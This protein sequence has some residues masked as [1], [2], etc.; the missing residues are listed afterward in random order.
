[1]TVNTLANKPLNILTFDASSDHCSVS[2]GVN[3][4]KQYYEL[5]SD[6]PRSHAQ[7]ILPM[8]DQVLEE[9][10]I[11]VS[12]VDLLSLTT[13]PGSFTGIRISVSVAQGLSYATGIPCLAVSSMQ[14]MSYDFMCDH[15]KGLNISSGDY[16]LCALDAR[17]QEVYWAL[18]K[19]EDTAS[20]IGFTLV[21]CVAPSITPNDEFSS[22]C[23]KALTLAIDGNAMSSS[24]MPTNTPQKVFGI[25]NAWSLFDED[26]AQAHNTRK[27][28]SWHFNS[29][30]QPTASG[31]QQYLKAKAF[32]VS[33]KLDHAFLSSIANELKKAENLEPLYL[34][35]EVSWQKRKRIRSESDALF[36]T[37]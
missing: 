31:I 14:A 36:D 9:A 28:F 1:M 11:R 27:D 5:L 2:L 25:G 15:R 18:Y 17:M 33:G 24:I 30:Q 19:Y 10:G 23:S 29:S 21:E 34:R 13:G 4:G 37:L 7:N 16:V 26:T 32:G 12:D 22:A 20:D 8:I 6:T 35:N 3:G